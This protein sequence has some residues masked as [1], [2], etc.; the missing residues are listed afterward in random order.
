MPVD[1]VR[2]P[3]R[4]KV[5]EVSRPSILVWALL[6]CLML[7]AGASL[8]I[9]A[10]PAGKPTNTAGFWFRAAVLPVLMW[11]LLLACRFAWTYVRVNA[12]LAT[13]RTADDIEKQRHDLYARQT[14]V[15]EW[16]LNELMRDLAPRFFN[17]PG[18]C[19]FQIYGPSRRMNSAVERYSQLRG[20][21]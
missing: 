14:E 13:N 5:P 21:L 17:F 4:A 19:Q 1:F 12:A 2:I 9:F 8:T 15:C 3:P 6:L 18:E 16:L 7:G 10:W 20:L 11:G